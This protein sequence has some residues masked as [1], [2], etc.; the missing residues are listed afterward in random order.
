MWLIDT[1]ASWKGEVIIDFSLNSIGSAYNII[2]GNKAQP[3][4]PGMVEEKAAGNVTVT[5]VDG[6]ISQGPSHVVAVN[7][8]PMEVQIFGKEG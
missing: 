8:Q 7:L 5:E 3:N 4:P 2:Y 6:S 1:Q